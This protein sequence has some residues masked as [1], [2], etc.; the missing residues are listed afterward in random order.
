[1]VAVINYIITM[2]VFQRDQ[3]EEEGVVAIPGT[4]LK[5]VSL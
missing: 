5:E 3:V 2:I 1:M 4:V